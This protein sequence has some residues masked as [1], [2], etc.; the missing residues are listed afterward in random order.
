M[1]RKKRALKVWYRQDT[2]PAT[3][4]D[5]DRTIVV[6]TAQPKAA[7]L[8]GR[9]LHTFQGEFVPLSDPIHG[10]I[11]NRWGIGVF[12]RRQGVWHKQTEPLPMRKQ[13]RKRRYSS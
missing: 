5:F 8:V 7:V 13:K 11:A 12:I 3:N 6:N 10:E 1:S 2:N 9:S 4:L